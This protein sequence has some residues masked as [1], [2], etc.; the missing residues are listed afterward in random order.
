MG[1]ALMDDS[2]AP[3][4]EF[5]RPEQSA[6]A[7][8]R[9]PLAHWMRAALKGIS[10]GALWI[11]LLTAIYIVAFHA[12]RMCGGPQTDFLRTLKSAIPLIAI[13]IS[14][15]SLIFTVQRTKAQRFLGFL[16][17]LAFILWGA[18]QFMSD[19]GWI[20]FIDDIVVFL[21]VLDLSIVVRENL[22]RSSAE[23]AKQKPAL[24]A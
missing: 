8:A 5:G 13:G 4:D 2:S 1:A 6:Q 12:F 20:S 24:D 17:G 3:F 16:V 18:E 10:F 7:A 23:G 22:K 14:Y 15:I 9:G 11:A 21:F 19:Q